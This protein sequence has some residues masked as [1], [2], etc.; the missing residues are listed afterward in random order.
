MAK[1]SASLF[2]A[3]C[4]LVGLTSAA[5]AVTLT[6]DAAV[7]LYVESGIHHSARS[8][9]FSTD[10]RYIAASSLDRTIKIW[11][12]ATGREL[13]T[14]PNDSMARSIA[15]LPRGT[16]LAAAN[17]DGAVAI[18]DFATLKRG[19]RFQ[20]SSND[21][22]TIAVSADGNQ[23]ICAD[24]LTKVIHR[25]DL[26]SREQLADQDLPAT[27]GDVGLFVLDA[28]H[29][30]LFD[31]QKATIFELPSFTPQMTVP[32]PSVADAAFAASYKANKLA[33][34]ASFDSINLYH[35]TSSKMDEAPLVL[36]AAGVHAI[37]FSPDGNTIAYASEGGDIVFLSTSDGKETGRLSSF[38]NRIENAG[39]DVAGSLLSVHLWYDVHVNFDLHSGALSDSQIALTYDNGGEFSSV[40]EIGGRRFIVQNRSDYLQ[41][42]AEDGT[43]ICTIVVLDKI[44]KFVIVAPD[45]R[46]DT[47]MDLSDVRGVHWIFDRDLLKPVPLEILM[48]DYYTPKLLNRLLSA[49]VMPS[50]P[51]LSELNRVQPKVDISKV[52]LDASTGLAEVTVVGREGSDPSQTNHKT[53]TGIY[54]VRLFRNG[55]LVGE[56][57]E[58]QSIAT[59]P[60]D[61]TA[62]RNTSRFVIP[63]GADEASHTFAVGLPSTSA[64]KKVL[65]TAYAFNEDRVKSP[66]ATRTVEPTALPSIATRR[67]YVIAVGVNSYKAPGLQLTY[68]VSDASSITKVL[69][70]LNGF[71]VVPVLLTTDIGRNVDGKDVPAIDHARKED[72]RDVL[73]LLAGKGEENRQRLRDTIGSV[74]DKLSKVTPDDL[75]VLTFSGHGYTEQGSFFILPS[76][77]GDDLSDH[78]AMISSEELTAWLRNVDAGEMVMIIDACHSAA[79]VPEGFKPGPMGDRGLGQLA[80]DKRMRILAATQADDVAIESGELGQGLLTYALVKEGLSKE[81]DGSLAADTDKDGAVSLKEWLTYA[82]LRVP[83]LYEDIVS[84]KV[85]KT[86]DS[87]PNPALLQDTER[88]AQTPVLFDFGNQGGPVIS[89]P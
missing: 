65:F 22:S 39:V 45:G 18:W 58:P 44:G 75:V 80:Y 35:S 77:S 87:N 89:R 78:A 49:Q 55:Q 74:A 29:A 61:Q 7:E 41:L 85:Q 27:A 88:H 69:Q 64:G 3:F 26:R 12:V 70:G 52:S 63:D 1:V 48:R 37:S 46:F 20:C 53:K 66:T 4:L 54:D 25:W 40:G 42:E 43:S 36:S 14:I 9:A 2:A 15:F 86:R 47:N 11:D 72:I 84:G 62:W 57:P 16:A 13:A 31:D 50:L 8:V 32:M 24:P 34:A 83:H 51:R 67:A 59:Q 38:S 28:D 6:D 73:A 79:G 17:E 56:W 21:T 76:D 81:T 33:L 60:P 10:G 68:A 5:I 82:Q 23:L 19:P 71:E 30:V